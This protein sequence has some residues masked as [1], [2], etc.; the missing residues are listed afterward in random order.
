MLSTAFSQI[1]AITTNGD[2]V[3]LNED[4]TWSYENQIGNSSEYNGIWKI[5]Y[6]VDEFGDP[7][8]SGFISNEI[9]NGTFSNSATTN[10]KLRVLFLIDEDDVAIMLY[11]Y[12]N[13]KVKSTSSKNYHI[14]LKHRGEKVKK[15]I[16][17]GNSSDRLTI[18]Y[19]K[20]K[21]NFKNILKDGGDIS[22]VIYEKGQY[23]SS[24]YK[25]KFNADGF[26]NVYNKLFPTSSKK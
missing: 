9:I 20:E 10:S 4:G 25:F 18:T 11:E 16:D 22:V 5:D 3:L 21:N 15:Y 23:A 13:R 14:Y 2:S 19:R 17:A 7:T 1:K 8:N 24:S 26:S 12:G 6:Y